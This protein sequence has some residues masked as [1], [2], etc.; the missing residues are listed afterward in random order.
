MSMLVEL[1]TQMTINPCVFDLAIK[2]KL[3]TAEILHFK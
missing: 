1:Q 2:N 3:L